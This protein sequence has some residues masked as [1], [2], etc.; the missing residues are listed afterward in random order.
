ML[1]LAGCA[2]KKQRVSY[3]RHAYDSAIQDAADEYD[4]DA[5]LITAMINV[6]SGF[7]P[8]A[9]SKSNA[10]GLMQLK[11]DTAGCDAY[12]YKGKRGCPDDDDL[13]DPDTNIDLGAAYLAVLQKQQLKG[14][15][16][17][18]TLRYAT[19]IAYVNGTGA[20]LRT[21]SSNRQQAI[22]MINNL[23]PEAFNWHV[24]KYHP[25]PQAPRHLMKV[26]TAYERL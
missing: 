22:A 19:I 1:V 11:A 3:D 4:V 8:A 10:I 20:L 21:F 5:K 17:P 18:V 2:G 26:E 15:D 14:I 12:R 6:E 25:A 9:V 24:R 23:S 7:N 13:L 16:N